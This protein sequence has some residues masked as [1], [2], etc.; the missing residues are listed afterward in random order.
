MLAKWVRDPRSGRLTEDGLV[1]ALRELQRHDNRLSVYLVDDD[2]S[3][4]NRII[5][6][7]AA[8]RQS[9]DDVEYFLLDV[10]E[11]EALDIH[12]EVTQGKT[13]DEVVNSVHRDLVVPEDSKLEELAQTFRSKGETGIKQRKK[14]RQLIKQGIDKRE[15][16]RDRVKILPHS[17]FWKLFDDQ[18]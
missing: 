8:T 16:D 1:H 15:I 17:S 13:A 2:R 3:N 7:L 14:V 6:A 11:L 18:Q 9:P 4:T 12:W 5:A 10:N